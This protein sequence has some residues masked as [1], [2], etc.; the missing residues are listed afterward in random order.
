MRMKIFALLTMNFALLGC[1]TQSTSSARNDFFQIYKSVYDE[2]NRLEDVD[3]RPYGNK[4]DTTNFYPAYQH[5]FLGDF[6][7]SAPVCRMG[8]A[9]AMSV[10]ARPNDIDSENAAKQLVIEAMRKYGAAD[11][12]SYILLYGTGGKFLFRRQEWVDLVVS[13]KAPQSWLFRWRN[14]AEIRMTES[15]PR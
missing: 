11:S 15:K 8:D 1:A 12:A 6:E 9:L 3:A 13:S 2:E 10:N 14:H 7:N 5:R 4:E